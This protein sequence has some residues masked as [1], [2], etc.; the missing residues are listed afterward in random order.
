MTEKRTSQ[1][2]GNCKTAEEDIQIKNSFSDTLEWLANEFSGVQPQIACFP[3]KRWLDRFFTLL[4]KTTTRLLDPEE[5]S[6]S[7]RI[8]GKWPDR[9]ME[10]QEVLYRYYS[11]D[12]LHQ[13]ELDSSETDPGKIKKRLRT[14]LKS[15]YQRP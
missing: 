3:K 10:S 6:L 13:Y 7:C 11:D 8:L 2:L 5:I 15:L 14:N 12:E 9:S 4:R 1:S